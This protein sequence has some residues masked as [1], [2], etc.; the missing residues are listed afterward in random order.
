MDVD[1]IKKKKKKKR[2]SVSGNFIRERKSKSS[3][4]TLERRKSVIVNILSDKEK[5]SHEIEAEDITEYNS[6]EKNR[7][8]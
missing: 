8:K 6:Y 1:E 5:K 4:L 2:N 3:R 7:N